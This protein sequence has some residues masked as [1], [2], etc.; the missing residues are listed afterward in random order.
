MPFPVEETDRLL[1][2]TRSVRRRLDLERPVPEELIL[3]CID[4]AEQ[5]PTGGNQPSRRWLVIRDPRV[6]AK[7]ADLYREAGGSWLSERASALAGSGDPRERAARSGGYLADHLHEVP[8]L[9][10]VTIY[11]EH[12]GSGRPGLFDSVIQAAWSFCLAARARGLGTAWTTLHLGEADAVAELLEIPEGVTQVV[13]LPVAFSIGDD[14]SIVDRRPAREITWFD[15]W[16]RTLRNTVDGRSPVFADGAGVTVEVDIDAKA[17]DIWP[18]VSDINLPARFSDE[19]QG[20]DWIDDEPAI[21]ARFSGRNK[22]DDLGEYEVICTLVDYE[23]ERVFAWH[24][25]DPDNPAAQWRFEIEPLLGGTRLR[26]SMVL[27]PGPSG[28][29][30]V[31]EAM[32]DKESAIIANRQKGQAANMRRTIE[33]IR[34]LA[35]VATA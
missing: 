6:K 33:G 11:G 28:L 1:S 30:V 16:G 18:L 14:F 4:L 19:F 32:P 34:D 21:G 8:A 15:K 35:E 29:T 27:G 13:L 10:L 26:F 3:D 17:A 12:D 5:A 20:A 7:L 24:T 31:I 22:R 2:T 23:P 9:V 25:R